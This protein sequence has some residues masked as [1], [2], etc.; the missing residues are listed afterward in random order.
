MKVDLF[1]TTSRRRESRCRTPTRCCGRWRQILSQTPEVA[2]Y[3]RR[4]GLQLGGGLTEPNTG[5]IFIRLKPLPRRPIEEVMNEIRTKVAN[6][7]ARDSTSKP[8]S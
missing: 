4:T 3:S 5:D 6:G 2:T 7:G 8:R 1:S